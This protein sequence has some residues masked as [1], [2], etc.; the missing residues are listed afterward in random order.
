L[1][2]RWFR[3]L[4]AAIANR[5]AAGSELAVSISTR[6]PVEDATETEA[7]LQHERE[8]A[9]SGEPVLTVPERDVA[10]RWLAEARWKVESVVEVSGARP[11]RLLIVAHP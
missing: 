9:N 1:P 2:E 4:L 3:E 8:L 6:P 7:R 5:A 10:L 11:G